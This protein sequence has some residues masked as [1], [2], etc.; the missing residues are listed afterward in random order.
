MY[1]YAHLCKKKL[2]A[3]LYNK[4]VVVAIVL[5]MSALVMLILL[6]TYVIIVKVSKTKQGRHLNHMH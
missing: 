1:L 6:A 3:E 2:V 4:G 5:T